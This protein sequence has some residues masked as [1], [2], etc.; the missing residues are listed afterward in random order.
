MKTVLIANR[1]GGCG[2]TTI[3]ITLAAALADGGWRVALAD[4]DPQKSSLR[5]LKRRPG[6]AARIHGLDWTAPR[7]LG[8]APKGTDW[9]FVDAPGALYG[10]AAEPLVAEAKSVIAPILPSFFDAESTRRFVKDLQQIKRIRKGKVGLEIV[11][12]RVR[13]RS[14]GAARLDA[15]FEAIGQQPVATLTERA[16]YADLAEE[17]LTIFDKPQKLYAPIRAQWTP[18]LAALI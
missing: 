9:L 18:L 4:A 2:K 3:A 15:F 1:K 7:R 8:Q 11:A 17:G 14:R 5:W 10:G 16:A 12:N 13:P 6:R